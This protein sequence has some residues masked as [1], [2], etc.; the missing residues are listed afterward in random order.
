MVCVPWLCKARASD[1]IIVTNSRSRNTTLYLSSCLS[2]PSSHPSS[3]TSVQLYITFACLH[4]QVPLPDDTTSYACVQSKGISCFISDS[5]NPLTIK[6]Y[7]IF[8]PA[9]SSSTLTTL[10][11]KVTI[12]WRYCTFIHATCTYCRYKVRASQLA[13]ASERVGSPIP[14]SQQGLKTLPTFRPD[15]LVFFALKKT[16]ASGRNVGKVFKPCCEAGIGEPTLSDC[17]Y[18][19]R[20]CSIWSASGLSPKHESAKVY[21]ELFYLFFIVLC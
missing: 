10:H 7:A 18:N 12:F 5:Y 17:R 16:R 8:S 14:A 4:W 21:N 1:S 11:V 2:Y 3:V 13:Q 9:V 19:Y 15:A 20:L 6:W